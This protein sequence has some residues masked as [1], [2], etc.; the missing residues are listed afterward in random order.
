MIIDRAKYEQAYRYG[1]KVHA[2]EMRIT[3]AKKRLE[4]IGINPNSSVDLV[5]GLGHLLNGHRYTR[6]LSAPVIGDY[7]LWIERDYD[8]KFLKNAV[9]A[10]KQHI[11]YYW[12]LDENPDARSCENS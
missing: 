11:E 7:L 8:R 1:Q 9:S 12:S 4:K 2:G 5:Y 6:T 10:L 3:D